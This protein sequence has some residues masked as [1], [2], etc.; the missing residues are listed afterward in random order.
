MAVLG[1]LVYRTKRPFMQRLGYY[2]SNSG[3]PLRRGEEPSL[4]DRERRP[5][6]REG[7]GS[8]ALRPLC[9]GNLLNFVPST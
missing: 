4:G 3:A 2:G 9:K 7:G 5:G 8:D 6:A 1:R